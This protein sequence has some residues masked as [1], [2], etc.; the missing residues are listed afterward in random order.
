MH[1]PRR[2]ALLVE[3]ST[4]WGNDIVRGVTR[5]ARE[6]GNW[7][8]FL[9]P[10]GRLERLRMPVGWNGDGVIARINSPELAQDIEDSGIPAVDVSW[11][12]FRT[13]RIARCTTSERLTAETAVKY[14]AERGFRRFAYYP[15]FDRAG[16]V[17]KLASSFKAAIAARGG[18]CTCFDGTPYDSATPSW[19]AHLQDLARWVT[20]LPKPTAVLGFNGFRSRLVTE[21]CQL[22]D[23]EVPDDI[24][25]L[26]A[27]QDELSSAVSVP[28]LSSVDHG[29]DR[30]GYAAAELLNRLM[31]GE[32]VPAKGV[33]LAPLGVI[34]RQSTEIL[35]IDDPELAAAFRF[36]RNHAHEPIDVHDVVAQVPL[37][38]RALEKRFLAAIG[39]TPA[40][41]IRRIRLDRA[42]RMLYDTNRSVAEI[43]RS[44]GFGSREV[45]A[46]VFRAEFGIT[47]TA[48]RRKFI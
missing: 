39:Q 4:T 12:N 42:K 46:R 36:I 32:P 24:A 43:A 40:A 19:E 34:S 26:C 33:E 30:I 23:L 37:S 27:E 17:D 41:T 6:K 9:E 3:T 5:Y 28:P 1:P 29:G 7:L 10:R 2:V 16:Y 14:L 20:E 31:T 44:C 45:M 21:A 47:P 35:A 38:R 18:T 48:F 15:S 25:V 11:F 8:F 22:A 13:P